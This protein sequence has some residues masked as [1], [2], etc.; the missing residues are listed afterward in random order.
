MRRAR[1]VGPCSSP[2]HVQPGEVVTVIRQGEGH[3]TG[4]VLVRRDV[5]AW[6]QAR[7]PRDRWIPEDWL[8]DPEPRYIEQCYEQWATR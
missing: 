1:F 7:A 8:D 5:Q 4:M 3:Y 6:N 2:G